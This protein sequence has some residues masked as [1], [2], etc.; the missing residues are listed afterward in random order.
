MNEVQPIRDPE[1]IEKMKS[2]LLKQS[3]RD[4]F[5]FVMGINTGL[6]ISDLLS[7]KVEDVKNKTHITI[8]EQKTGKMKRFRINNDLND[9]ISEY[10]ANMS[11]QDYLFKSK[12]SNQPIKRVQAY[13]ILNE[14]AQKAGVSE[15]GTHTLRKTFGYHFYKRT[16]DVALLQDIFNHSAPS[17]TLRY[18]GINQEVIDRAIDEFSL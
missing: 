6:R 4:W 11:D 13:K 8:Q 16:K 9:H 3:Y 12:R 15:I 10:I 2:I 17:I 18:I 14:A 7:L 1:M 5:M